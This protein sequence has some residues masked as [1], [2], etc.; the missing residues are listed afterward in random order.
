MKTVGQRVRW[1]RNT[2]EIP[3]EVFAANLGLRKM[4]LLYLEKGRG[5][6]K[7]FIL[8]LIQVFWGIS[9]HWLKTGEGRKMAKTKITKMILDNWMETANKLG[10]ATK[11]PPKNVHPNVNSYKPVK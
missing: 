10:Y 5:E 9:F 11:H 8:F 7:D 1:V 4:Q 6:P 2:L 3:F